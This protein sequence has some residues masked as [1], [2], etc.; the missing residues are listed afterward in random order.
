MAV[1]TSVAARR[2]GIVQMYALVFGIAYVGVAVLEVVFGSNGLKI[3]DTTGIVESIRQLRLVRAGAIKARSAA[4]TQ[5]GDLIATA[6]AELRER[7]IRKT[8]RG[9]ASVCARL[10]P[11]Q[12]RMNEPI[13]AAKLALRT[14]SE[15]IVSLDAEVATFDRHLQSLVAKAAP[16]TIAL[17]GIS[18][19]H[20]GQL[21]VTG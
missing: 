7:L 13:Q 17:L 9:Q 10:R 12:A 1:T 6:P 18:T 3:G 21:L 16:R 15:R 20:A 5:L 2:Y 8:L 19:G 14:L 4:L 11:D